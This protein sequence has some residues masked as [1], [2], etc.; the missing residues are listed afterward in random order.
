MSASVVLLVFTVD[1]VSLGKDS[2]DYDCDG[3][4]LLMMLTGFSLYISLCF[5]FMIQECE[6]KHTS[7]LLDANSDCSSEHGCCQ[8]NDIN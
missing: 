7:M 3:V 8:P 5:V 6:L 1:T 4:A 2:V